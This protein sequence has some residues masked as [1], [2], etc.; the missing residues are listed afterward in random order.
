MEK[1][2]ASR[3]PFF[4]LGMSMLPS[5]CRIPRSNFGS[6][7]RC[8]VSSC[9]STTIE[10]CVSFFAFSETESAAKPITSKLPLKTTTATLCH[11]QTIATLSRSCLIL[12]LQFAA[13]FFRLLH[14]AKQIAAQNL[15][16]IAIAVALA[17]QRSGDFGQHRAIV[18]SFRHI[19]A[20][21][22]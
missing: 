13:H 10:E 19:G 5:V 15:A 22:V 14:D 8:V 1:K 16:N 11:V 21:E 9:V 2:M 17:D 12:R 4:I 20:I 7:S 3:P 18:H 6:S